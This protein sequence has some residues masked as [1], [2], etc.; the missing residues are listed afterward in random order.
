MT[1]VQMAIKHPASAARL[2]ELVLRG[3]DDATI[4]RSLRLTVTG[5]V[6]V[7]IAANEVKAMRAELEAIG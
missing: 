3:S 2:L 4:V 7:P 1:L 5:R 6:G